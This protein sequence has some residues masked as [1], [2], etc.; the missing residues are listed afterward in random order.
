MNSQMVRIYIK[1][2]ETQLHFNTYLICNESIWFHM[3][4]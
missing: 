2:Y 4:H 3:V 1:I